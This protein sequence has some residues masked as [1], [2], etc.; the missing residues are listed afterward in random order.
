MYNL[1]HKPIK[2]FCLEGN[3]YS[4]SFIPRLKGEYISLI[5]TKMKM[6]G[7]VPRLDIDPDFTIEYNDRGY[8]DFKLSIYGVFVGKRKSEWVMGIDGTRVVPIQKS[9]SEEYLSEAA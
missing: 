3:V 4:D 2:V 6:F 7:Y 1:H 8:Y 5:K 9:K